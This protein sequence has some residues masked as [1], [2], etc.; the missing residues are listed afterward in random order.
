MTCDNTYIILGITAFFH[1]SSAAIIVNSEIK[2][3]AE[4]ERFTRIKY[5]DTFPSQA[6]SYCLDQLN[7]TIEDIDYVVFYEKPLL[8]FERILSTFLNSVPFGFISFTKA[9]P[10]WVGKK[11]PIRNTITKELQKLSSCQNISL[12]K[13]LFVE[14]HRSHAA[15][16]FF[17]S[18]YTHAAVLCIDGVGEWTTMSAWIGENNTLKPLWEQKFPNSLGLLY[19]AVTHYLGFKVNSAE[20][21]VMGLAPYGKPIY[22]DLIKSQLVSIDEDGS[23]NLNLKYFKFGISDT[24]IT[25]AFADVFNQPSRNPESELSQF[26][27]DMAASIQAVTEEVVIKLARKIKK[28][29]GQ[30]YL[31]LAGGIALNCVANGK[32]YREKFFSDIWVQPAS[33]D[34]GSAVGAA[35][36]AYYEH[37]NQP[38]KITLPDSMQNC[39]LGPRY[40]NQEIK[41]VLDKYYA[42]YIFYDENTLIDTVADL[43]QQGMVVG[44][45]QGRMEFGPR[46]L[47]NRSILADPRNTEMQKTL[48]LKIKF[49]ESFRPF[50]P[51]II[52]EQLYDYISADAKKSPYMLFVDTITPSIRLEYSNSLNDIVARR[53]T[54]PAVT[55]LDF[56]ARYQTVNKYTNSRFY[57]LIKAFEALTG[58]AMLVNTSFNI[59]GEPIVESPNDAYKCFMRTHM[60][61]LVLENYVLIKNQQPQQNLEPTHWNYDVISD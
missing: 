3:A 60:D 57:N 45:F 54:I 17:P 49:R 4:E 12:P 5:D 22:T 1:S 46:A 21:K 23:L 26:H 58:V 7:I 55:H 29:T 19:S 59:R 24:M 27:M 41:T 61:V 15:A 6:I 34:S 51:A 11:L 35:L 36:C 30:Y 56:S 13:Q 52:E 31:C 44:F 33:G 42:S 37:L 8:K 53:S 38:R 9:M 48:N 43:L 14:H 20:Y 18:P 32:L 28:D 10:H 40:S 16:A 50:A 39:Y 2:A 47:G 25:N